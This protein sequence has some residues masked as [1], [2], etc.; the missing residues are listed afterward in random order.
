MIFHTCR[1]RRCIA[2][3][4]R[5]QMWSGPTIPGINHHIQ[6]LLGHA[7]ERLW[8]DAHPVCPMDHWGASH[9]VCSVH[10][11]ESKQ[12]FGKM[13]LWPWHTMFTKMNVELFQWMAPN[14]HLHW[15]WLHPLRYRHWLTP[16]RGIYLSCCCGLL[17]FGWLLP[18][19]LW[20][21][22]MFRVY[23]SHDY[24]CNQNWIDIDILLMISCKCYQCHL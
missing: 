2:S 18:G 8:I 19:M 23:H 1:H 11:H 14:T 6:S 5:Y 17:P 13:T 20:N 12:R 21:L 4:N 16:W 22:N 10:L 24:A 15:A 7:N 3:R 9:R